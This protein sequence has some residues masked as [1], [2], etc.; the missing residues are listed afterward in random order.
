MSSPILISTNPSLSSDDLILHQISYLGRVLIKPTNVPQAVEFIRSNFLLL[1][2]YVDATTILSTGDIADLL[3][4]G[5]AKVFISPPQAFALSEEHKIPSDRL[6]I[7]VDSE[8]EADE[9]KAWI[10]INPKERKTIGL[11]AQKTKDPKQ[12]ASTLGLDTES[13]HIYTQGSTTGAVVRENAIRGVVSIISST[14]VSF[15][16]DATSDKIQIANIL[17]ARAV[18]DPASGLYAT[19]VTDE[20]GLALGL[21]WSSD[22]SIAEA[23]RTG[24]GV[25]QSRKRGLW[26][27]GQSSGDVQE[28]VRVGFDCDGDC[29]VFVVKQKGKGKLR[30]I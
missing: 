2:I 6:I 29:L 5:T 30:N 14:S 28:L 18:T 15:D 23:L 17:T 3:N 27:K 8:E 24:T 1:D 20:R 16:R 26:Y 13:Q 10:E 19:L 9:L 21:V 11:C 12:V 25:Y 4:G 7:N 22:E